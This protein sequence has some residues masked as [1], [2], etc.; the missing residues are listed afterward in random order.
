MYFGIR[1]C[2]NF[3]VILRGVCVLKSGTVFMF[4]VYWRYC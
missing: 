1:A 2:L 4:A 3:F